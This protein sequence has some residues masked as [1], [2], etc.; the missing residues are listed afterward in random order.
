MDAAAES[1]AKAPSRTF[2]HVDALI[3]MATARLSS[4][5]RRDMH[6]R[7]SR[8]RGVFII[9]L[10]KLWLKLLSARIARSERGGREA[11]SVM[12]IVI[13]S[14]YQSPRIHI[15]RVDSCRQA[16]FIKQELC[17]LNAMPSRRD[18]SKIF[19]NFIPLEFI[20]LTTEIWIPI[21]ALVCFGLLMIAVLHTFTVSSKNK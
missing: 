3:R 20:R 21:Q 2:I 19:R 17:L 6:A 12:R 7:H 1:D 13:Q 15:R 5:R 9:P 11:A 18:N 16:D 14:I 4:N 8:D 10:I